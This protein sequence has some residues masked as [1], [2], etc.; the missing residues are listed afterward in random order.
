MPEEIYQKQMEKMRSIISKKI[1]LYTNKA[2]VSEKEKLDVEIQQTEGFTI[3]S[4]KH[5]VL[6]YEGDPGLLFQAEKPNKNASFYNV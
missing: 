3:D 1:D 6:T 2:P 5:D 4:A